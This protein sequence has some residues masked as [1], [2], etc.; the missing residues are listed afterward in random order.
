VSL[1]LHFPQIRCTD[2][3]IGDDNDE[4]KAHKAEEKRIGKETRKSIGAVI[5]YG[6][7]ADNRAPTPE[8]EVSL[9]TI[10]KSTEATG[11]QPPTSVEG[12]EVNST[13]SHRHNS[14]EQASSNRSLL[15]LSPSN[16]PKDSG[17]VKGWLHK[18]RRSSKSQKTPSSTFG[19]GE[20]GPELPFLGGAALTRINVNTNTASPGALSLSSRQVAMSG[21]ETGESSRETAT[22]KSEEPVSPISDAG[23]NEDDEF[24]E[25]RDNFDEDLVAPPTFATEK[26]ASP[27]RTAKFTEEI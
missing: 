13:L 17:K 11:E 4:R 7:M 22:Q 27:T 24:Q 20:N 3:T 10:E 26:T 9:A 25:A 19:E 12:R 8:P 2:Y 18:L 23:G 5:G 21:A 1:F 14:M 6:V 15:V 16:A